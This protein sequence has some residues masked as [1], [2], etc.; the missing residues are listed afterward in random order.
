MSVHRF[1]YVSRVARHVRFADAEAI[2]Q[3]AS[4]RNAA[5]GLTGLLLYSPSHFVQILEGEEPEI[6]RTFS[7]IGKDRRHT[8]LRVVD[9]RDVAER[10]F[11]DWAMVARRLRN[12]ENVDFAKLTLD[13]ALELLRRARTESSV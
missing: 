12:S 13:S 1:I 6:A 7:R 2:A 9:A 8:E 10:E 3:L 4:E 11:S 5:N